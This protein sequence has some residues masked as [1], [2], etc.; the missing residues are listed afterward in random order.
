[1][2]PHR[3]GECQVAEAG[4]EEEEAQDARDESR[5]PNQQAEREQP[6]APENL[7]GKDSVIMQA[8]EEHHKGVALRFFEGYTNPEVAKL[9]GMSQIVVAVTVHRAR[10]K[11]QQELIKGTTTGTTA[12]GV[13]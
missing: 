12:K 11:L 7:I 2:A 8:K 4:Y 6:Q 10:K 3:G 13:A 5:A 9:M 1:M